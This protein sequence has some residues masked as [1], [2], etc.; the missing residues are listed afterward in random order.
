LAA[1]TLCTDKPKH[2]GKLM[3]FT[4]K[5]LT[6]SAFAALA[7]CGGNNA[8][9]MATENVTETNAMTETTTIN[10]TNISADMN[11][12]G[13]VDMNAGTNTYANATTNNAM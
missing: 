7:A 8:N 13:N 1:G 10:E 12:S 5:L 11:A 2:R 9:N 3:K 4:V 6:A